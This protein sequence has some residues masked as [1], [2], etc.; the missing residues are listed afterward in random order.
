VQMVL[1]KPLPSARVTLLSNVAC[2][3]SSARMRLRAHALA[4][5]PPRK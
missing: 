3:Q 4:P 5:F 2:H 1:A